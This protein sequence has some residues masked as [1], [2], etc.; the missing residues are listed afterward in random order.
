MPDTY[1]V[2]FLK[3]NVPANTANQT[4]SLLGYTSE[5]EFVAPFAGRISR[6][7][8]IMTEPRTAGTLTLRIQRNGVNMASPGALLIDDDPAQFLDSII[9]ESGADAIAKGDKLKPLL[10]TDAGWLPTTSD[11]II[12]ISLTGPYT[13]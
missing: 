13:P 10:T 2:S 12:I 6:V 4:T 8:I 5:T 1:D 11:C 7:R 9:P 3:E